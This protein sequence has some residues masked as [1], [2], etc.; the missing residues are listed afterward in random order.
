MREQ[1]SGLVAIEQNDSIAEGRLNENGVGGA[2]L[3][4]NNSHPHVKIDD[5]VAQVA[6]DLGR[7]AVTTSGDDE[8]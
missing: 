4:S 7:R 1:D 5:I 2:F 6:Q 8:R 3:V